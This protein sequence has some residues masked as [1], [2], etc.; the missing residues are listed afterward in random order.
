MKVFE[1]YMKC[2]KAIHAKKKEGEKKRKR[3]ES[4]YSPRRL[5]KMISSYKMYKMLWQN[6]YFV[7]YFV[8][9]CPGPCI[10]LN[11]HDFMSLARFCLNLCL[12]EKK[13]KM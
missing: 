2:F 6:K 11:V 4:N 9:N 12:N 5:S 7:R 3:Y 13:K 8:H 10:T 1:N